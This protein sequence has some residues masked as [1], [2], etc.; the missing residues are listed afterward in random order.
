M[1]W[2]QVY[3]PFNSMFLSTLAAA[4]SGGGAAG[5]AGL[6]CQGA[7]GRGARP[8]QRLAGRD[9]RLRNAGA[10]WPGCRP[11]TARHSACCRSAGSCSTS[12]SCY[13]LTERERARSRSCRTASPDITDDRRL[14]LLL[15]AFCFGA[16]F[17]G[18]AG[19]GTPV[20]VTRGDPDR[21]GLHA[22]GRLRPVAD[23]QY[24]AGGFGALGTPVD[25]AGRRDRARPAGAERH[26]RAA[27]AVLLADRAVLADLGLRRLPRDDGGLAGDPGRRR[28]A[29]P[30]RSSSSRTITG[31]GWST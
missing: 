9:R 25:R 4:L 12:S 6:S 27:A 22:A 13:Q 18:A 19:F 1:V 16:F 23:R 28:D 26:G 7:H 10:R 8:G 20:A 14:Q 24:R 5:A 3:D 2:S 30:S 15:V 29:S 21:P 17:E 31:R 11:C